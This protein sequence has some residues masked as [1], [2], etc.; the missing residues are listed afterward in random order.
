MKFCEDC[1][2]FGWDGRNP[3]YM[4]GCETCRRNRDLN[5]WFY[6]KKKEGSP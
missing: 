4:G 2:H 6:S 5:D 3:D 1:V